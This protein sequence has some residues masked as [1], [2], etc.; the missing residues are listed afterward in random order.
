MRLRSDRHPTNCGVGDASV[1]IRPALVS[2]SQHIHCCTFRIKTPDSCFYIKYC[3]VT[4]SWGGWIEFLA[5]AIYI[6]VGMYEKNDRHSDRAG[7]DLP[8]NTIH[9]FYI[10]LVGLSR[11]EADIYSPDCMH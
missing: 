3:F 4:V 8:G 10:H 11:F 2:R 9:D 1:K 7:G 6:L 5:Q